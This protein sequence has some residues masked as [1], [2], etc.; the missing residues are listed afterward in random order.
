M[1][2]YFQHLLRKSLL[3]QIKVN[4]KDYFIQRALAYD[5]V[6]LDMVKHV[7]NYQVYI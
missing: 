3:S 6:F 4:D 7:K 1:R 5:S 2:D